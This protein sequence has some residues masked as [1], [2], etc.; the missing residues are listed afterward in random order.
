M[1][2]NHIFID[3]FGDVYLCCYY[4]RRKKEHKLGNVYKKPIRDIWF[5]KRHLAIAKKIR[6]KE[7]NQMDCRW[8]KFNN[9]MKDFI[10]EDNL[11]QLDF[12]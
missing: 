4:L 11:R 10:Y 1:H 9:L 7:C 12:A 8:I 2:T 3:A 5:S 6:I